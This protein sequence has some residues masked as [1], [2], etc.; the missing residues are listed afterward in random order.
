MHVTELSELWEGRFSV[1][2]VFCCGITEWKGMPSLFRS[3]LLQT[4]LAGIYHMLSLLDD[5][6]LIWILCIFLFCELFLSILFLSFVSSLV[7][8]VYLLFLCLYLAMCTPKFL[9]FCGSPG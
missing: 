8:K 1:G 7:C 9:L 5:N 3:Y 2:H 4:F 6:L